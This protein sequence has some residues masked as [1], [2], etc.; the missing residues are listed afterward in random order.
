MEKAELM[1]RK[2]FEWRS[3]FGADD[4]L[5]RTMDPFCTENCIYYF[6][7][8]DHHGHPREYAQTNNV[9]LYRES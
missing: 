7:G 4:I 2:S 9:L 8:V 1:I 5:D 6:D 3:E